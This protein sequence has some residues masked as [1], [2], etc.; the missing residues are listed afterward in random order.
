MT[1]E[2]TPSPLGHGI[3]LEML[4][5]RRLGAR[6]PFSEPAFCHVTAVGTS[7]T[8]QQALCFS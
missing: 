4:S 3:E 7:P 8:T 1:E 5:T 2:F 6:M